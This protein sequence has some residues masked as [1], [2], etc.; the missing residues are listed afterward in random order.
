[1]KLGKL[2]QITDLVLSGNM[3]PKI[4]LLGLQKKRIWK[5]SARL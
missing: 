3:K 5:F 4:L 2:E 1:M